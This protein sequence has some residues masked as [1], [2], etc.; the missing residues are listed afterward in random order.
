MTRLA[1]AL[2]AQEE[3]L[4]P[5]VHC[6]FCLPACP[7]Y[8]R[9]GDEN[10]SPRGRLYLMRAVVE[11]RLSA[12]SYAFQTHI[13]RCLGC[14][15]CEPVCPS[16]VEYG[17]LLESARETAYQARKPG[18]SVR[19]L[20]SVFKRGF[21]LRWSMGL[22]R[23]TR[24]L[25]LAWLGAKLIPGVRWLH[26]VRFGFAMLAASRGPRLPTLPS[27]EPLSEAALGGDALTAGPAFAGD[28]LPSET[29]PGG[30]TLAGEA[31]TDVTPP[32]RPLRVALLT[33]CVQAGLFARVNDATERVLRANGFDIVHVAGQQ[34]CGALHSHAGDAESARRLARSN[35][36]VLMNSKVDFVTVNA[37][38]CGMALKEYGHLLGDDSKYAEAAAQL[39]GISRDVSELLAAGVR[40]GASVP[41]RVTYDAACHL[42]HAQRLQEAPRAM[43]DAIPDL[44]LVSLPDEEE[45]CGGAG[46][47]GMTHPEL[48]GRIGSDKVTAVIETGVDVVVTANP[49]CIMQ[50][51]AGLM[52]QGSPIKALHPVELLDE[53][54]ERAGFYR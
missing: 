48:G 32:D 4:L 8:V 49:G 25:G 27:V 16:G 2:K 28:T 23:M 51:G 30:S 38:G 5:C 31:T 54:Y 22:A 46:I 53:S 33:G 15:A 39:A 17:L 36:D 29:V 7:T 43:L 13:D 42:C 37:A 52:L 11:G 3:R 40:R 44:D 34:C 10:D 50:I 20:L 12:S 45:C 26:P 47:Y 14:R 35:V 9:L 1:T 21:L 6:G 19:V 18:L 24:G 41:R